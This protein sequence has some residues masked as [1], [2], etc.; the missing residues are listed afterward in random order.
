MTA[1]VHLP[2][3]SV[4]AVAHAAPSSGVDWHLSAYGIPSLW[5]RC[6]GEG[7]QVGILD[8]GIE[9]DHPALQGAVL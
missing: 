3:Y 9:P 7:V 8:T 4:D 5:L 1:V 6:Q 2:P